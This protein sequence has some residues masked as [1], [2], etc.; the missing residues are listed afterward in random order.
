VMCE[1]LNADGAPHASNARAKLSAVLEA[2]GASADPW[3]GF[4]QEYT[5][6]NNN[7]P[8]GWPKHGYPGAQGPY[9]C[10]VGAEQIFGRDIVE[11]HASACLEAGL[12]YY[13]LNAEVM[14]GQWE[15]QIGYRGIEGDDPSAINICDNMHIARWLLHRIA[16][17]HG[18]HVSFDNKPIKGDWNGAG[19]HA[20]FSTT[21]TRN[22]DSGMAAIDSAVTALSKKHNQHIAAY[23]ALLHERLTGEHETADISTFKSGV[24]DRGSSIRIPQ[25]VAQ[26]GYGY[27][28]DRRP[29][30]NACPY[31]VAARIIATVADIDDSVLHLSS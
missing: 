10:G 22:Q 14:P 18:A 11:E 8:L 5:L 24:A 19:M 28:E 17:E 7:R 1:V 2:G 12:V 20:N 29:G 15:F 3:F 16:E 27:L 13:G 21:A 25:T 9:Y 26:Q 30:A 6:F 23:G 31:V 4:E